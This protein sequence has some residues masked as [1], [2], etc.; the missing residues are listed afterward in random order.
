[1]LFSS[2]FDLYRA[3]EYVKCIPLIGHFWA[4]ANTHF[5]IVPLD[6]DHSLPQP[7]LAVNFIYVIVKERSQVMLDL[8]ES[9]LGHSVHRVDF[10]NLL[11][12]CLSPPWQACWLRALSSTRSR[13]WK[14]QLLLRKTEW[15]W[16]QTLL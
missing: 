4:C 13:L 1:M 2:L 12:E 11:A 5:R 7:D 10:R 6:I 3:I 8:L 16:S 15:P 9:D 14:S